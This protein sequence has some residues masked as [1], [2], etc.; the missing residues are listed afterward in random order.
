MRIPR[1]RGAE[2]ALLKCPV[3]RLK[4]LKVAVGPDGACP[5]CGHANL[6]RLDALRAGISPHARPARD[7]RDESG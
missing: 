4:C 3:C 7:R 6:L 2:G 5:R 1:L